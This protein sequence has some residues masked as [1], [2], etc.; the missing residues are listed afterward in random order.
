MDEAVRAYIDAIAA[1][2][3]PLFDRLHQLVMDAHPD[4]TMI[5]SYKMPT[6]VV[7]DRRLYVAVW[8]HGLSIYGW[9]EDRN[10]GFTARH[11]E[12]SSDK[13]TIGCGRRTRQPYPTT[14]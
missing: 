6:Y 4:A 13:G 11:P 7:G 10:A 14:S 9:D 2:H 1:E 3:R 5:L 12:L 8:K